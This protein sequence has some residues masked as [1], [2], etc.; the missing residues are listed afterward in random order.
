MS[1]IPVYD[2]GFIQVERGLK[3][4]MIIKRFISY[5]TFLRALPSLLNEFRLAV[6]AASYLGHIW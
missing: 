5:L 3:L 6:L 1:E 2:N 4:E